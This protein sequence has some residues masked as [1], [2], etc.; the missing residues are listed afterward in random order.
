MG[1]EVCQLDSV[2]LEYHNYLKSKAAK[3]FGKF[4]VQP[5]QTCVLAL[6][7]P[8]PYIDY[9]LVISQRSDKFQ[10]FI[11]PIWRSSETLGLR[12]LGSNA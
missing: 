7:R 2:H 5:R 12:D 11:A 8:G 3:S 10:L 1:A 9:Y 6:L 4:E